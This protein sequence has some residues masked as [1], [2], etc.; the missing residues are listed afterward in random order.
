MRINK[1]CLAV[2]FISIFCL[3]FFTACAGTGS[4]LHEEK[5]AGF[6]KAQHL[7]FIGLDG[8]GGSY[9]SRAEMPTAKRMMA[10]G[11]FTLKARCIMPSNSLPNWLALFNGTPPEHIDSEQY[12]SIFTIINNSEHA[13]KAVF[14]YEWSELGDICT[15]DVSEKQTILS[16]MESAQKIGAYIKETKP[17]FTAVVFNEP[18]SIGHNHR[19]GSEQYYAKLGELDSYIAI[20]EQAVKDAGIYDNTIFVLS[21]DHGGTFWGHGFNLIKQRRIPLVVYGAGIKEGYVIPASKSICDI[22]PTMAFILGLD[23]P[24]EW[25]GKPIMEIFK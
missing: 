16:D 19:W 21:S 8:W 10:A 22:A 24:L 4:K 12:P 1:F 23:I 13:G 3:L 5:T 2:N 9:T 20:I 17:V 6:T 11:S 25:K 14:F 18:D 15:D 7:V